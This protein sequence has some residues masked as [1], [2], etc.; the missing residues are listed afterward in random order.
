MNIQANSF[1]VVAAFVLLGAAHNVAAAQ[2]ATP[3][4]AAPKRAAGQSA[5]GRTSPDWVA[6]DKYVA[7]AARDWKTPGMAI[8]IVQGDSMVFARGY[9]LREVGTTNRVDEHSRF[10][11]GSTTKAMTVM[12]LAMLV[13]EGKLRY[14][15]RVIDHIP[16]FQLSDPWVTREVTVRDLLLHRTGLP[17]TDAMWG[18]FSFSP[19]EMMRRVRYIKP[20]ASFRTDW[21]YQNV[22][23]GVAGT[24][25]ERVSKMS[26]ADFLRTRIF[27]PL[28]MKE[29]E[30]LV[31]GI[32]SKPNVAFPHSLRND[33][34]RVT[35][36]GNTDSIAPAGSVWSSVYDMSK[37][38]R[39]MLDSGRVGSRR[40]VSEATFREIV[41]P[42]I[43]VPYDLYPALELSRPNAFSYGFGWFIQDYRGQTVWMHT[44]SINGMSAIIG[45]LPE[46]DMGVYVLLNADHVELRHAL[47]YQAFDLYVG[48]PARDWSGD[49]LAAV[50]KAAA[51][52][53]GRVG[54]VA[55]AT[56]ALVPPSLPLARYVGT[57]ADSAYGTVQVTLVDGKLRAQLGDEPAAELEPAGNERFRTR[58]TPQNQAV[59]VYTFDP[60]GA[61][62]VTGVRLPGNMLF[63]RV[64]AA[65][66]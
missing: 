20:T 11:I 23:Y 58:A 6:F 55:A 51:D 14:D 16:E 21:Q 3:Q 41:T 5:A 33:T 50:N 29:T 31:A 2:S 22:M 15:D 52:A 1:V 30:P 24:L 43:R 66:R 37:W 19:A 53:A 36:L 9:G 34:A 64:T 28:D 59:T 7:Q 48:G 57:F 42:Q 62:S 26:W 25:V 18:R 27:G 63:N 60:D 54:N 12:A 38:M 44:G 65:R 40:L 39:F 4:R 17:G 13:D 35:R 61:G 45:L 46:K 10:A 8:A 32:L 56:A 49:L 47:I